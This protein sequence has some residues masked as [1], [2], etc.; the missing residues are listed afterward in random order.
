M[1]SVVLNVLAVQP[2]LVPE[3]LLK[4]LVDEIHD[5]LPAIRS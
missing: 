2:A 4:L 1:H 5:R 3:I